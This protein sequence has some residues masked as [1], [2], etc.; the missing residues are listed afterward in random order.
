M[1]PG[2][3]RSAWRY[4]QSGIGRA[5]F[6]SRGPYRRSSRAVSDS[7]CACSQAI[8]AAFARP[9]VIATAPSD[10]PTLAAISRCVRPISHFCLRIS[11]AFRMDSRS[12]AIPPPP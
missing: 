4:S 8:P 6:S 7:A 9:S 5:A 1:T 11:L 2:F 3:F 12:V 10:C